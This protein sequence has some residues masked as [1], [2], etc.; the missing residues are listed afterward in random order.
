LG[1][2]LRFPHVWPKHRFRLD[3]P[4]YRY[5]KLNED[6]FRFRWVVGWEVEV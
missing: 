6:N 5:P 4:F 2:G 3:F 1:A